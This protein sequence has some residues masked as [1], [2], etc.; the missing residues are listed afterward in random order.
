M[1]ILEKKISRK[2]KGLGNYIGFICII[3]IFILIFVSMGVASAADVTYTPYSS[4]DGNMEIPSSGVRLTTSIVGDID[5]DGI[6]DF[7]IAQRLVKPAI[8]W[9][10][11]ESGNTWKKYPVEPEA[12]DL[13]VGNALYDVDKDGDLDIIMFSNPSLPGTEGEAWWWENPG[14]SNGAVYS[15]TSWTKHLIKITGYKGQHDAKF[16]DFDGDGQ[17]ELAWIG[18]ASDSK[19]Y[20]AEIPADPKTLWTDITVIHTFPKI[21]E[22][23][24]TADIDLDGKIDIVSGGGW[25]K[26][27]GATSY[28]FNQI[29]LESDRSAYESRISVGQIVR[30]K[31]SG[32][33]RPE[34]VFAA[35]DFS[36]SVAWYEWSG[37]EE[38]WTRH[39]LNEEGIDVVHGHSLAMG[40]LDTD[41]DLDIFVAEMTNWST[42]TNPDSKMT[43]YKNNGDKTFTTVSFP[44]GINNHESKLGDFNGDGRLDILSKSYADL[45]PLSI[46]PAPPAE[47]I[48]WLQTGG[49]TFGVN[50]WAYKEI[51][52][53]RAS[54][55][56]SPTSAYFFGLD[57]ADMN[58]DGY[59]D[60][61]SGRYYYQ[62]PG[63]N[64]MGTWIRT[65]FDNNV[66]AILVT[67]IDGDANADVI[68]LGLGSYT[69]NPGVYWL[70]KNEGTGPSGWKE[71]KVLSTINI[72]ASPE[73]NSQGFRKAQIIPG[74]REEIV[75]AA[76]NPGR[77]YYITIPAN[78]ATTPWPSTSVKLIS[79]SFNGQGVAVGDIDKDGYLD[80]AGVKADKKTVT[81][82]KNP[83][84]G[85]SGWVAHTVG[86]ATPI[87]TIAGTGSDGP[88]RV[89]IADLNGDGRL[90]IILTDEVFRGTVVQSNRAES[91]T[92]WFAQPVNPT[93]TWGS[94]KEIVKQQSTNSLDVADVD[95]DGDMDVVTGEHKGNK[96]LKIWTNNGKGIFT[97][98]VISTGKENHNGGQL[99]DLDG[100]GDLDIV[101]ITWNDNYLITG[102]LMHMW[103]N[104]NTFE[105]GSNNSTAIIVTQPADSIVVDGS[106]ATFNVNA[107]GQLPLSYQWQNNDV[108]ITDAIND[109]YTI[110]SV[111]MSDNGS[112]YRVVVTNPIGSVNSALASLTVVPEQLAKQIV[113]LDLTY[114]HNV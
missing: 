96:E 61:V 91:R 25:F 30:E 83:G 2:N 95:F 58:N 65:T 106:S 13:D 39:R 6:D 79:N 34:V 54:Y 29:G 22:G 103:R 40:D 21:V 48:V 44:T 3:Q 57:F 104:D 12:M 77:L 16:G 73:Y 93:L 71:T 43:L 47:L 68:A 64:M 14:T 32:A 23:M 31:V 26:H 76:G 42:N 50:S 111:N 92:Y 24:S 99:V 46:P 10:K 59:K 62:N 72:P 98:N 17:D 41:G 38:L 18:R 28:T 63:S 60:I 8:V 45:G 90:D 87:G 88:D 35:G 74:G 67:N 51:D 107:T 112:T 56:G 94:S 113:L 33:D 85:G 66:D 37:I 97:G 101:S 109:S 102:G 53:I 1:K 36:G 9:Y 15:A 4:S 86:Y 11:K 52:S 81:W 20:V 69:S 89:E 70:E 55:K 84:N 27:N 7:V 49:G 19:I 114:T 82:W 100:D 108:N 80:V 5:A 75:I 105:V 110:S 78:P